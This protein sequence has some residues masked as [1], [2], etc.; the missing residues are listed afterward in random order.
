M[1][2]PRQRQRRA[3]S[4]RIS[5]LTGPQTWRT[6]GW[7]DGWPASADECVELWMRVGWRGWCEWVG[8][9]A[10]ARR[11]KGRRVRRV[12]GCGAV[13]RS[14]AMRLVNLSSTTPRIHSDDDESSELAVRVSPSLRRMRVTVE[15]H[16]SGSPTVPIDAPR[17]S[18]QQPPEVT[19]RVHMH[20]R[21][22]H[23]AAVE[24]YARVRSDMCVGG[25]AT[26]A[27]CVV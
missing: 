20:V 11:P 23:N 12:D 7:L 4:G 18:P 3:A 14:D 10:A 25:R 9:L 2:T 13:E 27:L 5:R 24:S 19:G 26:A 6:D 21:A 1:Q 22:S 15:C 17:S 16:K 8:A